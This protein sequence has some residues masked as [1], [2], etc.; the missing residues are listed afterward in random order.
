MST[1]VETATNIGLT[2]QELVLSD[3]FSTQK[4]RIWLT[5]LHSVKPPRQTVSSNPKQLWLT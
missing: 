1:I 3:N 4:V 2:R 5:E